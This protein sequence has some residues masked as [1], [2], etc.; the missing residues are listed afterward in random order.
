MQYWVTVAAEGEGFDIQMVFFCTSV[1][2]IG[3][4]RRLNL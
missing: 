4:A 1:C 3:G 2:T